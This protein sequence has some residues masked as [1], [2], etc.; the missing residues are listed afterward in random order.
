L[1]KFYEV[2]NRE[3]PKFSYTQKIR[4]KIHLSDTLIDL[5][6]YYSA[7]TPRRKQEIREKIRDMLIC[8]EE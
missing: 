7:L 3:L 8:L 1:E 4:I 2:F 5:D 6:K